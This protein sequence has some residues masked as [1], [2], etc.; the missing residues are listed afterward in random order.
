M[1]QVRF[2]EAQ[3]GGVRRM[4]ARETVESKARRYLAEGRLVV[5]QVDGDS[6]A[7]ECRGAGEV[8][9]LGHRTGR[10]GGW[11]WCS[12]PA[13]GHC[14]HLAALQLVTAVRRAA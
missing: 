2:M 11:W 9:R 5:L 10:R 12:C 13:K 3:P 4:T 7:A 1:F 6:I 8:Y 14:C